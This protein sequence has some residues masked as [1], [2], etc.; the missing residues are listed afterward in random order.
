MGERKR[1]ATSK[2]GLVPLNWKFTDDRKEEVVAKFEEYGFQGIQVSEKHTNSTEY[3]NLFKLHSIEAAELYIAIKCTT[4]SIASDSDSETKRQIDSAKTGGVEM[5]VFAVDGDSVRDQVATNADQGPALT[6]KALIEL[7]EHINKWNEY[8]ISLGMLA[9]FHPHAATY[10]ET[11][12][13]TAALFAHLDESVGLCLDVG[14]WLVGGGDPV[15]AVNEYGSR[16]THVHVKDVD[17]IALAKLKAGDYDGMEVAVTEHKL[18]APAGTGALDLVGLFDALQ[19]VGFKGWLMSEQ[20]S[21]WAPSEE[22]SLES[23]RNIER[24]L[25]N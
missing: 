17:P 9:S 5:I 7:A 4:E 10:I 20:D 21:A 16:I 13:E 3:R 1:L 25:S 12:G 22:K 11:P 8:C 19:R 6:P 24:A 18:F 2:I 14:H 15:T 23:Y